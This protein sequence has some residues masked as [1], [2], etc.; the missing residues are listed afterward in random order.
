[1]KLFLDEVLKMGNCRE[2]EAFDI[3]IEIGYLFQI[4]NFYL[5]DH[6]DKPLFPAARE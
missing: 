2:E 5:A 1:L 3:R 6:N 4:S